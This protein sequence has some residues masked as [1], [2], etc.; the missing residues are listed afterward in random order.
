MDAIVGRALGVSP[1]PITG[2]W[3][4][5]RGPEGSSRWLPEIDFMR[6][7]DTILQSVAYLGY[8]ERPG[9]I[10]TQVYGGTGF[11]AT[12]V[13]DGMLFPYLVTADH[14]ARQLEKAADPVAKMTDISGE[15]YVA[16]IVGD[17]YRHPTDSGVDLAIQ[18]FVSWPYNEG[19]DV[20]ARGIANADETMFATEAD[21]SKDR[22]GIGDEVSI[23]GRFHFVPG[24]KVNSPILRTGNLAM[25]P[26]ERIKARA[27]YNTMM[28]Y[29]IEA[30]SIG[31]M[32]GGPVFVRE[33][34]PLNVRRNER[35]SKKNHP[36]DINEA[37]GLGRLFLLG[38]VHGHWDIR[39]E[40]YDAITPKQEGREKGVNVGVAVIT[41]VSKLSELL[42][43]EPVRREREPF[44]EAR[45]EKNAALAPTM[46]SAFDGPE[47]RLDRT[48]SAL[49]QV[50]KAAVEKAEAKRPKRRR[51]TAED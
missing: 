15:E 48:I 7:P 40:D 36:D 8:N 1:L 42:H 2:H 44:L 11:I 49:F 5:C 32:S 13:E 34:V 46:D 16:A 43:S 19:F 3:I 28:A 22:I 23:A 24:E 41:P 51:K 10:K 45:R 30:R 20:K 38:V 33:T 25:L 17:W 6:V 9:D 37:F 31:Q 50:P 39:P 21:F 27:P 12:I 26:P 18:P 29:L 35:F 47:D 14:V 4:E